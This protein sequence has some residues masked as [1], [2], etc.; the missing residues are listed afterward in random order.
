MNRGIEPANLGQFADSAELAF[1]RGPPPAKTEL[2]QSNEVGS[3]DQLRAGGHALG[4]RAERPSLTFNP[5]GTW[6]GMPARRASEHQRRGYREQEQGDE[7]SSLEPVHPAEWL[8]VA[9]SAQAITCSSGRAPVKRPS[10]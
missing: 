5:G 7:M 8:L 3:D 6:P 4:D 10:S 1:R 9:P 2:A